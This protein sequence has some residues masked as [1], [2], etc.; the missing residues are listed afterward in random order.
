MRILF[1][2]HC[3]SAGGERARVTRLGALPR[4]GSRWSEVSVVTPAPSHATGRVY[5]GCENR[6]FQREAVNEVVRVWTYLAPNE[7]F[8]R[9]TSKFVSYMLSSLRW[10]R[11]AE[12]PDVIVSTSPQFFGGLTGAD[13]KMIHRA[14][15]VLEVR[16]LWPE[17]IVT[18]GAMR[19]GAITHMLKHVETLAYRH[20]DRIVSVTSSFVPHIASRLKDGHDNIDM[21]KNGVDLSR[22]DKSIDR[23]AAKRAAKG[24]SS[25]LMLALMAW[26]MASTPS[27]TRPDF[28]SRTHGL[29][30]YW[31]A[32]ARSASDLKLVR[33][34]SACPTS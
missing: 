23:V 30:F 27:S 3:Y 31:W 5:P 13:A 19:K 32:T 29:S 15:W 8:L 11:R 7:G 14:P 33:A 22:F 1:L 4:L 2:T 10:P 34:S 6:L 17:S 18:V 21:I 12:A 20:A 9:R 24:A 28:C 16:D 25:P 26:R